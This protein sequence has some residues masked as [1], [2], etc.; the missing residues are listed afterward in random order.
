MRNSF[1]S[2]FFVLIALSALCF[3]CS[4]VIPLPDE[5]I[6]GVTRI[7]MHN[8]N[9][10]SVMIQDPTTKVMT[11]KSLPTC[12]GGGNPCTSQ[13]IPDVPNDQLMWVLI[14]TYRQETDTVKL[15]A[16]EFHVHSEQD[17]EGGGWNHGKQG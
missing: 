6:Q 16:V 9:V 4:K 3:G 13:F 10:Y 11:I 15:S 14:K 17:V 7:F 5:T 2:V 1:A 8:P 12:H